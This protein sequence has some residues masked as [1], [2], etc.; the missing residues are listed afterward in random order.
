MH[1]Q[2][3]YTRLPLP[4]LPFESLG[5]RLQL[6]RPSYV[7]PLHKCVHV[8]EW[9]W[10]VSVCE[11]VC[12][13]VW[14]KW[15]CVSVWVKWVCVCVWVSVCL[16]VSE[17]CFYIPTLCIEEGLCSSGNYDKICDLKRCYYGAL[18]GYFRFSHTCTSPQPITVKNR[19]SPTYPAIQ[20]LVMW[21]PS[22]PIIPDWTQNWWLLGT[23]MSHSQ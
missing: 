18:I 11:W 4:P 5:T 21:F 23:K 13:C 1:K 17:V 19:V 8:C 7:D 12:V 15:V 2:C 20:Q 10:C 16:C 9:S 22:R 3:I 6:I 14:V